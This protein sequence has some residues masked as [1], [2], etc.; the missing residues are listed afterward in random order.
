MLR[1]LIT[2]AFFL[3]FSFAFAQEESM[4]HGQD[5]TGQSD[6][7]YAQVDDLIRRYQF[8]KAIVKLEEY[9][10]EYPD[11]TDALHQLAAC[12]YNLGNL[13]KAKTKFQDILQIDSTDVVASNRLATIFMQE[14][15]YKQAKL[16][17]HR[18]IRNDSTNSY[19]YKKLADIEARLGFT[20]QAVTLYN[21]AL[22]YNPDDLESMIAL[23]AIYVEVLEDHP[24]MKEKYLDVLHRGFR[25]DSLNRSLLEIKAKHDFKAKN[26]R[27]TVNTLDL[28]FQH[29]ADTLHYYAGLAGICHMHLGNLEKA[30]EWFHYIIDKNE[31]TELTHYYLGLTYDKME[32]HGK[33]VNHFKTAIAKGISENMFNYYV[34]LAGAYEN[35]NQLGASIRAYQEAYQ[36]NRQDILLYKLARN[37][38]AYYEDKRTAIRYY[39]KFLDQSTSEN[40]YATYS[41][42]RISELSEYL[43]VID[44]LN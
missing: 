18:L 43:H 16:Y 27:E 28:I 6:L 44:T 13:S 8:N 42:Q 41:A 33:A 34:S 17:F 30:E 1:I 2:S 14:K 29:H 21:T 36:Y 24:E 38:D 5:S 4:H 40:P 11:H 37:Y 19:Y 32:A 26:Y 10:R 31:D 39:Q 22:Q 35:I 15:A 12:H 3:H 9:L 23:S 7:D 25:L 20:G